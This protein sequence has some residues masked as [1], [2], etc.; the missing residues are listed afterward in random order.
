M[1]RILLAWYVETN[2]VESTMVNSRVKVSKLF[3]YILI[4]ILLQAG[5]LD[6]KVH[7]FDNAFVHSS[8][9]P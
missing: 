2:P 4:S 6:E 7:I 1:G 9:Y 5:I 8:V 3:V